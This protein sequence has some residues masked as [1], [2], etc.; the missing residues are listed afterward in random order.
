MHIRTL[1][2]FELR[3]LGYT[4]RAALYRIGCGAWL[5]GFRRAQRP[6]ANANWRDKKRMAEAILKGIKSLRSCW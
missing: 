4:E 2:G 1:I 6:L 5:L 3:V